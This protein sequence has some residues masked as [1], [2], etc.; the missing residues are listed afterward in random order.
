[1]FLTPHT[2]SP[3]PGVRISSQTVV[4]TSSSGVIEQQ[5]PESSQILLPFPS[6]SSS[7]TVAETSDVLQQQ[8]TQTLLASPGPSVGEI[9][10]VRP[11]TSS[12]A[13][14]MAE[15]STS[16]MLVNESSA[17]QILILTTASTEILGELTSITIEAVSL[18][19]STIDLLLPTQSPEGRR[20]NG[21]EVDRGEELMNKVVCVLG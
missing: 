3:Q 16:F 13:T 6:L 8:T 12:V 4:E 14:T 11:T 21:T 19:S 18:T 7:Q 15:T 9:V 10:S 1:M 2:S 20:V 5:L 17:E